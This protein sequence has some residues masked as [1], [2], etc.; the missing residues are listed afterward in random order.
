M[1]YGVWHVARRLR[2]GGLVA[3]GPLISPL[4]RAR[5]HLPG[6]QRP[7]K[8]KKLALALTASSAHASALGTVAE[9]MGR[10]SHASPSACRHIR[11]SLSITAWLVRAAKKE[12]AHES[13]HGSGGRPLNGILYTV[14][15]KNLD[16]SSLPRHQ[17]M[18]CNLAL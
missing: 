4:R 7:Q 15:K 14:P 16:C 13:S 3:H 18:L 5:G 1:A 9:A 8:L 12:A 11:D 2:G 6:L 10:A 17:K